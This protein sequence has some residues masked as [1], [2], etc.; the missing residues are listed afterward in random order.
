VLEISG[1]LHRCLPCEERRRSS[2][3]ENDGLVL[4]QD[5]DAIL[6]QGFEIGCMAPGGDLED[7]RA[8]ANA[9]LKLDEKNVARLMSSQT[10]QKAVPQPNSLTVSLQS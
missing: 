3:I 4:Q 5:A 7:A 9:I 2:R 10:D 1:L 6:D 8:E